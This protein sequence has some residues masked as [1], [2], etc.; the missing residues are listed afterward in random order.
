MNRT[1]IALFTAACAATA[2]SAQTTYDTS[3]TPGWFVGSGQPNA[4]FVVNDN[5]AEGAQTGLSSFYRYGVR[6]PGDYTLRDSL[7]GNVYTYRNGE[8]F[9]DGTATANA[10][11]TAA[12][13]FNFHFNLDTTGTSGHALGNTATL[14]AIDWDPTAGVDSHTYDLS[15]LYGAVVG[16][17]PD[18]TLLQDSWNLGFDF[19][20]DPDF[21]S[22]TGGTAHVTPFDPNATGQYTFHLAT[23]DYTT[24]TVTSSVDM[25]VNVVPTPGSAALIGAGLLAIGRRRRV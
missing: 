4:N 18:A 13:N 1:A 15:F 24:N 17:G 3:V 16:L 21:L 22:V 14:L 11:G 20:N 12:W 7:V 8:S 19:W 10:P 2:A 5:G 23:F 6:N 9:T 25:V